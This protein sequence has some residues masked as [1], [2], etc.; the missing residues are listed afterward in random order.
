MD[1]DDILLNEYGQPIAAPLEVDG[2][3][4]F[5]YDE[6]EPRHRQTYT[7]ARKVWERLR[8]LRGAASR[9]A[10]PFMP[11]AFDFRNVSTCGYCARRMWT[12]LQR[13]D[14]GTWRYCST[15]CKRQHKRDKAREYMRSI[16]QPKAPTARNC[17]HCGDAFTAK[18]TD[19]KYC[20]P[21]CR[22]AARRFNNK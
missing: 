13:H 17:Q 9:R 7:P 3:R 4:L 16:R 22:Q 21:R 1:L 8:R 15:R 20:S 14:H 5:D 10:N 19:A 18:R 11:P 6:T 12:R 2:A